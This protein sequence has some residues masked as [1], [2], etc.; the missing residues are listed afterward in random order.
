VPTP[1]HPDE[2]TTTVPIRSAAYRPVRVVTRLAITGHRELPDSTARLVEASLRAEISRYQEIVGVSC[3]ADGADALFAQAVLA[4]GGS[5]VAVVPA[6]NYREHLPAA[7]HPTYDSLL[8]QA[9]EVIELDRPVADEEAFM[10]A[11]LRMLDEAD[12]LIAVW[13]GLPARG[14]GGTSD[15]VTAARDRGLPVIVVWPTGTTR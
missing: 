13:D 8:D 3:V 14:F 7:H 1:R 5:L 2:T 15:V 6:R 11:S 10:A 12:Q 4:L 9:A